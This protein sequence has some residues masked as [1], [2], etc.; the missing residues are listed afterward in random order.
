MFHF[1]TDIYY[2]IKWCLAQIANILIPILS[3]ETPFCESSVCK[4]C[5]FNDSGRSSRL[6]PLFSRFF[7][8]FTYPFAIRSLV[9]SSAV[10]R[11]VIETRLTRIEKSVARENRITKVSTIA[12][13][14]HASPWLTT[15]MQS[16][17]VAFHV[18]DIVIRGKNLSTDG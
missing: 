4:S 10:A 16:A 17:S 15:P 3:M 1:I 11:H 7:V 18:E 5:A 9:Y 14:F 13:F 12:I 8:T 6:F 2:P